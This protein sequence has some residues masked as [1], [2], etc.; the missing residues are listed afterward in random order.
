MTG[1]G[2]I[3]GPLFGSALYTFLGFAKTFFVCGGLEVLL[4]VLIWIKVPKRREEKKQPTDEFPVEAL[5]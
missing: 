4:A 3:L 5:L 2:L 1:I